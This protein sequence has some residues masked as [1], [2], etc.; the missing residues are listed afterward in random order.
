LPIKPRRIAGIG[1]RPAP[2]GTNLFIRPRQELPLK[3]ARFAAAKNRAAGGW[4]RSIIH[5]PYLL[6][7]NPRKMVKCNLPQPRPNIRR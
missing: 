3:P 5:D 2:L 4:D 6:K 1:Q 7:C